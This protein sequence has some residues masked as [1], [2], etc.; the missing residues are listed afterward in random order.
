MSEQLNYNINISGNAS[1]S[2]G[3][4]KKQLREAQNEVAA[5]S[6]KFGA[7]SK[8]AI[9]AAKR[10]AELRDRIGDARALTE[11]FNPDA[12]FKALSA[13]LSGVA[14]GFAAVQGAIGLFGTESKE[15]EKQLLRVQSALALSQGLQSIGES[16]DSF[17]QLGA[18]IQ[19]T[20]VFTKANALA[21]SVTAATMKALGIA[22]DTTSTSFKV[23][24]G[25]IAATG[26]GLLIVAIG[27]LAS[28]F[29][30]YTTKAERAKEAQDK[31]NQSIKSGAE[32]A[33]QAELQFIENERQLEIARAKNRGASEK[34][35]FEL[36]QSFRKIRGE[37]QVRYWNE[38][39]D[40]DA[41]GANKARAEVEKI[42][43]EG[44]VAD[45]NFQTE[46]NNKRRE[47]QQEQNQK[48]KEQREEDLKNLNTYFKE[49]SNLFL[50]EKQKEINE[51]EDKYNKQIALAKKYNQDITLLEE[52]R[53]IE[54]Q[55]VRDKYIN[56]RLD[57]EPLIAIETKRQEAIKN[58][59]AIVQ[60]SL[61]KNLQAVGARVNAETDAAILKA[62]LDDDAAKVVEDREQ[63]KRDA[64]AMTADALGV[65]GEVVG[66]QTAAGKVLSSAQA[67]INTFLGITQIWANK[68]TIPEPFGTIQKVAATTTAAA[69]GFLAVRNIN[70][71]Q[72]P[73]GG[74]GVSVP[75]FS[76]APLTPSSASL[77]TTSLSQ[78]TI[79]AI[80]NQAI[81][82]YVVETDITSNQ[83]RVQA[84]K[85][86]ARF[87]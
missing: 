11:A 15:L 30:S 66:Q 61:E 40:I 17:K 68:T 85:Q 39:K 1:E 55:K 62:K 18:V 80:G 51:I 35:I 64:Y 27:E 43:T 26:I 60:G 9:E 54:L 38:I 32:V 49:A 25:A 76:A 36:E 57:D 6:D 23:L 58:T 10:A 4:L 19:S 73:K 78:Q 31:L 8:E 2:V 14:G 3:S 44:A 71:V 81:R 67:L 50:N 59:D 47:K 48:N 77:L 33:L 28:A 56:R 46:Q 22:V 16:I 53:F 21:N 42:N 29:S 84:I 52:A 63:A 69:S 41:E 72:V 13:S 83:K 70:K 24:K 20:T 86:R 75:S 82:A 37:A 65:L 12:K 34:E 74:G 5:L 45:L 7:T 87:S 79:N